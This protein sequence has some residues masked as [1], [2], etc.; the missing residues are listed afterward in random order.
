MAE[1][2]E[3]DEE[4]QFPQFNSSVAARVLFDKSAKALDE[5]RSENSRLRAELQKVQIGVDFNAKAHN[6]AMAELQRSLHALRV[7]K[8]TTYTACTH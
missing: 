3:T 6:Q 1:C 4:N 2:H 8:P 7:C 5:T